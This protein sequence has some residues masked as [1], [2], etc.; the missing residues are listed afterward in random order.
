MRNYKHYNR[1]EKE[2]KTLTVAA[3]ILGLVA[4]IGWTLMICGMFDE[5]LWQPDI[6]I[7][8]TN[9]HVS[10]GQTNYPGGMKQ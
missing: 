5:P 2:S 7:P 4:I 10:W 6:E 1:Y 8:M 3:I 9:T